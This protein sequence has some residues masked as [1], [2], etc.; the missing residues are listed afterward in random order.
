MTVVV[1]S[2]ML[3]MTATNALDLKGDKIPLIL[4]YIFVSYDRELL[5]MHIIMHSSV[6]MTGLG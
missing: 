1:V 6:R 4:I 3:Q 2:L 5:C